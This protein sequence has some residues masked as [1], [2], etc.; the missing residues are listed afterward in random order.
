MVSNLRKSAKSVDYTDYKELF[1]NNLRKSAKSVDG[2]EELR[3]R[4][5][6]RLHGLQGIVF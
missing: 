1:S 3:I 5:L 4:R 6:R 2:I